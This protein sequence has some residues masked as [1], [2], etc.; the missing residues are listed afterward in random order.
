MDK[1]SKNGLL[2]KAKDSKDLSTKIELL[3]KDKKLINKLTKNGFENC[4]KFSWKK[5]AREILK[6]CGNNGIL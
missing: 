4:K 6:S 1:D 2:F 3:Y 5:C